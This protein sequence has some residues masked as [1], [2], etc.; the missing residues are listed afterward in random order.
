MEMFPDGKSIYPEYLTDPNIGVCPS[1][2]DPEVETWHD[3]DDEDLPWN[4]CKFRATSYN[5]FAWAVDLSKYVTKD[6]NDPTFDALSDFT[7]EFLQAQ[8]DLLAG[9]TDGDDSDNSAHEDDISVAD[10]T[11]AY[12]LREGIE[13]FFISDINNPAASAKAQSDIWVMWDDINAGEFTAF[14]NHIPGGCNVMYMDGH[15]EFVKYPGETPVSVA[16]VRLSELAT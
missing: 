4:P 2:A 16:W 5:Y 13:R 8:I 6:E 9:I 3:N 12:R 1:D 15:V 11:T 10:G 14:M 7:P